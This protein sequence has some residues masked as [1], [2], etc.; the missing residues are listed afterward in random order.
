MAKQQLLLVDGDPR[1]VRVLEVSLKNAGFN[2]TTAADGADALGKLEYA[3]PDLI[4]TDTRLPGIDGYEMVRKLKSRPEHAGIPI[5]FL[6]SQRSIEDKIRGLELGVEDYLTKPIFVRELLT[7]VNMLLA[8]RTQERI[9]TGPASRTRFAGSLEDMGVVDLLQTIEVSRKSGV[10][11]IRQG[12]REAQVFFRD[13]KLVDAV[14]G[15]LRGEEAIYRSLLWTR[16]D[17]EV[18]FKPIDSPDQISTSTQGLLME[19]MRRVD[20]W[21]RLSEQL[22]SLDV[23]FDVEH[24]TL[25]ERLTEIPDELNSILRLLDGRRTLIDIIDESPFDDLSTLSVISK[26]YF[27]G[28]LVPIEAPPEP[29]EEQV[30]PT[31]QDAEG[32]PS[33]PVKVAGEFDVV[34]APPKDRSDIAPRPSRPPAPKIELNPGTK[35]LIEF[36]ARPPEP[37]NHP[38]PPPEANY[39]APQIPALPGFEGPVS[40]KAPVVEVAASA[41]VPDAP[42][43]KAEPIPE[44][45][46]RTAAKAE[47]HVDEPSTKHSSPRTDSGS[48]ED[49]KPSKPDQ[50]RAPYSR[51]L[52]SG[53]SITTTLTGGVTASR[54]VVEDALHESAGAMRVSAEARAAG[55]HSESNA[56]SR[57]GGVVMSSVSAQRHGKLIKFPAHRKEDDDDAPPPPTT[58]S[59]RDVPEEPAESTRGHEEHD[60]HDPLHTDFFSAGDE[61]R[62]EG[63]PASI[64][65]AH[66]AGLHEHEHEHEHEDAHH[67][68]APNARLSSPEAIERRAR[69]TRVVAVVVGFLVAS[70]VVGVVAQSLRRDDV[71]TP[72]RAEVVEPA[73]PAPVQAAVVEKPPAPAAPAPAETAA[74]DLPSMKAEALE[75]AQAAEEPPPAPTVAEPEPPPAPAPKAAEPPPEPEPKAAA[76]KEPAPAAKPAAVVEP[77]PAPAPAAPKPAP[78]PRAERPKAPPAAAAPRPK[79]PEPQEP[80]PPIAPSRPAGGGVPPTASFPM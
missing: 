70:L 37:P 64:P 58:E 28:L 8:R 19:G 7:R 76:P 65:P 73:S 52:A 3:A 17:F 55:A 18:E 35:T 51:H 4:L 67:D 59:E 31:S 25:M 39:P 77:K 48:R 38:L 34:P 56:S 72:P 6:T 36:D 63:G 30:V 9:A 79:K 80:L 20:E 74:L 14:Y 22:P 75:T 11:S 2:V 42:K 27:E 57:S 23:V 41:P 10:A 78:A 53:E 29:S 40:P 66:P 1:S 15:K 62:Y 21:G 33:T 5:V 49:A 32:N 54:A 45:E 44:P 13:G 12:K 68:H 46:L 26:L 24:E 16:G 43:P 50:A 71:V 47:P 60:D 61:G 69:L